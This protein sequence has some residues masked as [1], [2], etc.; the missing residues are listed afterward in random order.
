MLVM[1][2]TYDDWGN[3]VDKSG[4]TL[5][6][7]KYIGKYG[8]Y[9]HFQ[10]DD[11][12]PYLVNPGMIDGSSSLSGSVLSFIQTGV[13]TYFPR[14]GRYMQIDPIKD[15]INFLAYSDNNPVN[16]ID[17]N[18]KKPGWW[19]LNWREILDALEDIKDW[20]DKADFLAAIFKCTSD[21]AN[22]AY[23]AYQA[24]ID[25]IA[26]NGQL[27][28]LDTEASDAQFNVLLQNNHLCN[29]FDNFKDYLTD[30]VINCAKFIYDF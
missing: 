16:K 28:P 30:A 26:Q 14:I 4:S 1:V 23:A 27:D 19:G 3:L 9:A 18:G 29:R 11:V 24:R 21:L 22:A 15:G 25:A 2:Y 17:P 8:Y 20:K 7:F 13:R 10:D 12:M 6:P 5:Q